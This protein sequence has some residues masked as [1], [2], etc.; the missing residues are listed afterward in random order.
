M[1][2]VLRLSP[3]GAWHP[4]P[5][6]AGMKAGS[7]ERHELALGPAEGLSDVPLL[8]P[9]QRLGGSIIAIQEPLGD[10]QAV[11]W[12]AVC[13]EDDAVRLRVVRGGELDIRKMRP[14]VR[15]DAD[16][17]L[18]VGVISHGVSPAGT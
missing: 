12:A 11:P 15:P 1:E 14:Q 9:P 4:L 17:D 8:E 6:V 16:E 2:D 7:G 5:G 10:L 13:L 3:R 18:R